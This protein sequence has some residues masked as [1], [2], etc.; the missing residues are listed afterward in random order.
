MGN[1][2]AFYILV[3]R[4]SR[5]MT[6][7]AFRFPDYLD[8]HQTEGPSPL[9]RRSI[10]KFSD[11]EALWHYQDHSGNSVHRLLRALARL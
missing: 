11:V 10:G 4:E 3:W 9:S 7:H 6:S 2:S 1:D 5:G 8:H